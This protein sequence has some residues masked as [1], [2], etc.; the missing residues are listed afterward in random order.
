[1]S[2]NVAVAVEEEKPLR[3][4]AVRDCTT[5]RGL[6]ASKHCVTV[7]PDVYPQRLTDFR[8]YSNVENALTFRDRIEYR[9]S[10]GTFIAE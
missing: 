6:F 9:A 3:P 5:E 2:T 10:D 8:Y 7:S 4:F 1:M